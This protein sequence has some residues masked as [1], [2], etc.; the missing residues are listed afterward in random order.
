MT[1]IA[2][3]WTDQWVSY[4]DTLPVIWQ[5]RRNGFKY[6]IYLY[7]Y[8][9]EAVNPEF[10][11]STLTSTFQRPVCT[12]LLLHAN[13]GIV[14]FMFCLFMYVVILYS[15]LQVSDMPECEAFFIEDSK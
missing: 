1:Y 4:V 2:I 7:I 6:E 14:S 3:V 10:E 8:L 11:V 12:L 15:R 9:L 5:H 13:N